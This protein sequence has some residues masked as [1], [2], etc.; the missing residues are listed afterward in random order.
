M[1]DRRKEESLN[2][3]RGEIDINHN[4][5]DEEERNEAETG[6]DDIDTWAA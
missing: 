3:M 4:R 1:L 2:A 6:K 5:Y